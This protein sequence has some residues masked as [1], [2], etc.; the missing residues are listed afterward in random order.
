VTSFG[1]DEEGEIYIIGFGEGPKLYK[2]ED[3]VGQ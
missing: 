2:L 3:I 1:V